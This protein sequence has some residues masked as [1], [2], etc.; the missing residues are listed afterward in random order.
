MYTG[1]L[2]LLDICK[3]KK[4]IFFFKLIISTWFFSRF[5]VVVEMRNN[6]H[7]IKFK[8]DRPSA[9]HITGLSPAELQNHLKI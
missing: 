4:K 8:D 3:K 9:P 6:R 5:F 1:G 7:L 2:I